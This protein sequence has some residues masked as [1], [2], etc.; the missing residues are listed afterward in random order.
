MNNEAEIYDDPTALRP[1]G[2]PRRRAGQGTLLSTHVPIRLP[3]PLLA[4]VRELAAE[5]HRTVSAWIRGLIV[6]EVELRTPVETAATT[7]PPIGDMPL[8]LSESPT[9]NPRARELVLTA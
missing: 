3:R 4:R 1:A 7:P 9:A 5:D 6:K 2:P 8:A